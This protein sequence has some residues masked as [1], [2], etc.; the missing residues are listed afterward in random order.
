MAS[1]L[2]MHE[3]GESQAEA[4]ERV[5]EDA[6]LRDEPAALAEG[7]KLIA[8]P[9]GWPTIAIVTCEGCRDQFISQEFLDK[10]KCEGNSNA[11]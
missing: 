10:H 2:R 8:Y 11:D 6:R 1:I 7:G 3:P 4:Y 9:R 5:L